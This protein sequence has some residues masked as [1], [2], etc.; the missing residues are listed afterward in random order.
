MTVQ[1]ALLASGFT[2][3]QIDALDANTLKA[4]G[5]ILTTAEQKEKDA[6]AAAAKAEA[7]RQAAAEAAKQAEA[8]R[9]VAQAAKDAA[10]LEKRSNVEFYETKIMP[11]LL[12]DSE[13]QKAVEA[14]LQAGKINAEAEIAFYKAQLEGAK[15]AGFVA[16]D[17]P[18]W[19]APEPVKK[20]EPGR[21]A[22][23]RFVAGR[24]QTPGSPGFMNEAEL[25]KRLDNGIGS[26]ADIQ[27]KYQSLYGKPLPISPTE[28]IRQAESL[29]F[30]PAEYAARTF[31]F[32]E[33]EEEQR[34]A[35]AQAHDDEIASR[36][37]TEKQKEHD[38]KIA[39]L[40]ARYEQEKKALAEKSMGNNPEI[41]AAG[42]AKIAEVRAAVKAGEFKD[43][44]KMTDAERRNQ[45][46][47][48]VHKDIESLKEGAVA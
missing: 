32:A 5:G 6:V 19:K 13:Q 38:A 33:K 27:W 21:G 16:K 23:G 1:E 24:N 26:I 4:F 42:P 28:L 47:I 20:E 2:K 7:D 36:I 41:R 34:Q 12:A 25:Y 9:V 48:M 39:E 46:R 8:I 35:L 40:T 18:A 10:E 30:S 43:P 37:A 45:T 17:A 29:K 15:T 22:D 14:A 11:A 3:E 31:K 44:L